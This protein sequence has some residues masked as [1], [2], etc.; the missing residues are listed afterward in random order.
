MGTLVFF[1]L[2]HVAY[3]YV[4]MYDCFM[5]LIIFLKTWVWVISYK[6]FT[7]ISYLP[8]FT[9]KLDLSHTHSFSLSFKGSQKPQRREDEN[10]P[11]RFSST[12][13]CKNASNRFLQVYYYQLQN[14]F[15]TT[16]YWIQTVYIIAWINDC[17]F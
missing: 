12:I 11:A 6:W 14:N 16:T 10:L 15:I 7:T 13:F 8:F 4:S 3:Q 2:F 9:V 5:S 1:L 17:R